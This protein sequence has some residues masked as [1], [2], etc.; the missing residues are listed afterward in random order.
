MAAAPAQKINLDAIDLGPLA[1]AVVHLLTRVVAYNR[2]RDLAGVP[3]LMQA[4]IAAL[5]SAKFVEGVGS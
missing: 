3:A 5:K 2:L 1:S 4:A